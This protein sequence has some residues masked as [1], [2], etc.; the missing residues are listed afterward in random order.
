MGFAFFLQDFYFVLIHTVIIHSV[1][2]VFNSF[3]SEGIQSL[4]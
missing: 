1:P 2:N 4:L 3:M